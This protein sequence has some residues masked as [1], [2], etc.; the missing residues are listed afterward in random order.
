MRKWTKVKQKSHKGQKSQYTLEFKLEALR[1]VL[2]GQTAAATAKVLGVPKQTLHGW[3]HQHAKGALQGAC[4]KPITAK[5]A[6]GLDRVDIPHRA[7]WYAAVA[8]FG[9]GW[10]RLGLNADFDRIQ[11]AGATNRLEFAYQTNWRSW[12][13]VVFST[14]QNRW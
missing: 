7:A 9:V 2:G 5:H 3:V 8:H 1:L 11:E 12:R 10:M 14:C 4:T 6:N 13:T